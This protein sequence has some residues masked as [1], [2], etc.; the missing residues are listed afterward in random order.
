MAEITPAAPRLA[1]LVANASYQNRSASLRVNSGFGVRRDPFSGAAR[2]HTGVALKASQGQRVGA[3]LAGT[4]VYA[5][6]RGGYGNL[7]VVDHGRGIATMYGHLSAINVTT[8]Q[9]VVTGQTVG[10]VG[11]TG[12]STGPHLHYEV[13]ARGHAVDP[14]S[15]ITFDGASVFANGKLV[16]GPIV[17][18]GDDRIAKAKPGEKAPAPLPPLPIYETADGGLSNSY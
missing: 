13:R 12:R 7:V 2:M 14:S 9:R 11:S 3:S 6:Q 10:Q 16:E 4:V 15:L 18:G 1:T 5:G 17:E 8:G